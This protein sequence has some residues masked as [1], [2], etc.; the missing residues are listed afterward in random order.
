MY[1]NR[2]TKLFEQNV[3][4]SVCL[5]N[6]K[7]EGC[8]EKI[9]NNLEG[10]VINSEK[11]HHSLLFSMLLSTPSTSYMVKLLTNLNIAPTLLRSMRTM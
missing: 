11:L 5:S 3:K 2:N 9:N 1:K 7:M 6:S 4:F 10:E 8:I